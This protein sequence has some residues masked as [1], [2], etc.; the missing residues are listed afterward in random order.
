MFVVKRN[1]ERAAVRLQ[2]VQSRIESLCAGLSVDSAMIAQKTV[3]ELSDGMATSKLDTIAANVAMEHYSMHTDYER[4]ASMLI[5]SDLHKEF[6]G[7]SF[8]ESMQ[9]LR[10]AT[11]VSAEINDVAQLFS[12]RLNL[13]VSQTMHRDERLSFFGIQTLIANKYLLRIDDAVAELPCFMFM[14]VALAVHGDDIESV[15][16]CYDKLTL[17]QYTHATPTLFNAGTPGN[18]QYASCFLMSLVEDSI[19]GIYESLKECAAISKYAGGIGIHLHNLRARG[20]II[21]S[22]GCKSEGLVPVA[23]VFN[24]SSKLVR[25]SGKRPGSIALYM[26]TDHADVQALI[27]LRRVHGDETARARELFTALWVSDLFMRAVRENWKEWHLF[28]PD[29]APGLADTF[30][31]EYEDLYWRYVAEGRSMRTVSPRALFEQIAITQIETGTPYILYKDAI[32]RHNN[33]SNIGVVKSSN[34]CCEI[35]EVSTP[36]TIAVC[37]LASI[38]LSKICIDGVVHLPLLEDLTRQAVRALDNIVT[39]T[40]Y[41]LEKAEKS[42]LS[43]RPLGIG[44]QGW[45]TLLFQLRLPFDSKAAMDLNRLIFAHIYYYAWSESA[46]LAQTRGTY[47]QFEGSPLSRGILHADTFDIELEKTL[48]WDALRQQV[49]RGVRNSMLTAIMPTASTAQICGNTEACEP[50][51]SNMYVRRTQ[52]GEFLQINQFLVKDLHALGAWNEDTKA[53]IIEMDG[54]IQHLD[55]PA[56]LKMLYRTAY[57]M[58][59]KVIID[60]AADR[61]PYI[62]Q[63]QSM[64]LFLTAPTIEQVTSMQVYAFQKGLKTGQYYLRSRPKTRAQQFILPVTK[65]DVAPAVTSTAATAMTACD[66]GCESC[67]A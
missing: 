47:P 35:V 37:N 38:C 3:A 41:P 18:N 54:S 65:K 20:S 39:K 1:G 57:E 14:R 9:R 15:I 67:S 7:I 2:E 8:S 24:E 17:Q 27:D 61:M 29:T 13:T 30:G 16:D 40:F 63:S 34:L 64:N 45:Q 26:S 51:A 44:V 11:R 46:R 25:Q 28:S 56:E 50:Q 48:D 6:K 60:Q 12:S 5:V 52:A 59:Q 33:Q 55:V 21:R 36:D 66:V 19:D 62:D 49:R 42:N 10:D 43:A 22:T 4:L 53:S 31:A 32:N 58:S 23:R